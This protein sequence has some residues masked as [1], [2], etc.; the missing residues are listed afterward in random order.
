MIRRGIDH[1][2]LCVN[3]LDA[4]RQRYQAIGFTLTP[5]AQHPFG[6]GNSLAQLQGSFLELLYIAA[7]G[8]I[9]PH[10]AN[11]FSF[12]AFSQDYLNGGEGLS[13]LVFESQD[14]R[15]DQAE[16]AHAGLQTYEPFDFSRQATLPDR[17]QVTVGFSLA[18]VTHPDL[19]RAAFFTCQQHAP[20]YFWKPE[21]QG[22]RNTAQAVS[23]VCMVADDPLA[24]RDL[25][26]GLQEPAALTETAGN[27][28]IN[29]ARGSVHVLT[30]DAFQ[31]RWLEQT[32]PSTEHG[33]VFAG[34]SL[35]VADLNAAKDCVHA[36]GLS[37][38]ETSNAFQIPAS[39]W[40]GVGLEFCN[41]HS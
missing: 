4:A 9:P 10:A 36:S 15:R 3:D 40:F 17:T 26:I 1:L 18:F 31:Q 2:V 32:P 25:F 39:E 28:R 38:I 29:T 6:T 21:Y 13:M 30:P 20:E 37:F 8:E 34:F 24:L 33:A 16:F 12:A 5:P 27:L 35:C 11:Q 7:P 19:R 41:T 14:A 23:E 22:H